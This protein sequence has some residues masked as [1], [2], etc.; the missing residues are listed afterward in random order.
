MP[1][2]QIIEEKIMTASLYR[3]AEE[4]ARSI[5]EIKDRQEPARNVDVVFASDEAFLAYT[6]VSIAS[7]LKSYSCDRPLRVFLL[8][9]KELSAEH[10]R[11]FDG[12][13]R[14]RPFEMIQIPIDGKAYENLRT[15][16]GIS[17]ATYFRLRMH[18]MLPADCQRVVYL[19]SDIVVRQSIEGLYDLPLGGD[20]V[21]GVQDSISL[22]YVDKLNQ[23]PDTKHVNAGI[24]M[25]D[26]AAIRQ[27]DFTGI[28]ES[29][30]DAKKYTLLLGDQQIINGVLGLRTRFAPLKWNVH[31]SMFEPGWIEETM[32]V[33]NTIDLAEFR[34][35]V[36]DPAIV[37]YTY[38]RKPWI[39]AEHPRAQEW[40]NYLDLT[41]YSKDVRAATAGL[42]SSIK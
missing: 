11:R 42:G 3:W 20:V 15:T 6:A 32:G 38:K 30:I 28:V 23:H 5:D 29:F 24:L 7:L 9:D 41:E 25:L 13:Q 12:L 21:A 35:A 2:S 39:A 4:A 27:I 18:E 36:A 34:A 37:H 22:Y 26:I 33:K 16:P 40:F 14:I 19:D 31:G 17:V 1:K 8:L 10:K